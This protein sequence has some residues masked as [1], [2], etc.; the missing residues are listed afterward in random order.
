MHRKAPELLERRLKAKEAEGEQ[1]MVIALSGVMFLAGF[2]LAGLRLRFQWSVLPM[3]GVCAASLVFLIGY[4]MFA[5]VLREN[6]YLSRTIEVQAG[7]KVVDTGLY[8][9]VRHPMYTATLLMFLNMPL[10]LG[11]W[12]AFLVFLVYP[13]LIVKRIR[14]EEAVL[15]RDLDGYEAYCRKNKY[16]LIPFIW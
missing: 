1:R 13:L 10:I 3:W 12:Q 9:I 16:R 7:Q 4:G 6:A 11:S 2:V 5:L 8:G 14:N 15:L